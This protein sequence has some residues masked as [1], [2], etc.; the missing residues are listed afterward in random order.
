MLLVLRRDGAR[1][2]LIHC[3]ACGHTQLVGAR[4]VLEIHDDDVLVRCPA[5]HHVVW[6]RRQDTSR[7]LDGAAAAAAA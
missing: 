4:A 1:M 6:D 7:T 2:L 3:D 5:G